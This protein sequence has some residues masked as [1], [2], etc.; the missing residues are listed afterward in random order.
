[1]LRTRSRVRALGPGDEARVLEVCARDP[2]SNVFVA[3]RVQENRLGDGK[4]STVL[5][6]SGAGAVDA[7]VWSSAN[8]V[9][10]EVLPSMVPEI[11]DRLAGR[12]KRSSSL[13]GPAGPVL[14]LWERLA[15][16]WGQA[17][18]IRDTQ[19]VLTARVPPSLLG[20]GSD[21]WV[22]AALPAELEAVLPA[23]AAMFTEEI[24]YPPYRDSDRAYRA[25]V[26]SLIAQ[27]RTLVRIEDGRVVFKADLGAV[28]LGV[29]QVQG[30]WV[31]PERRGQGLAVPAMAAVVEHALRH[32]AATVSLYVNGFNAPALATYRRVGF[33]QTGTFA[34][35]LL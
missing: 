31:H 4:R 5:G 10:V 21:P 8:V 22:R 25:S 2:V 16:S 18:E 1:M 34:T 19:P 11:A 9:P 32:E 35:V 12:G 27:G 14:A 23:A 13:F 28:A 24:G 3:A 20:V 26:T 30:V 33:Q 29:A 6:Y 15:G 7:L 17:R